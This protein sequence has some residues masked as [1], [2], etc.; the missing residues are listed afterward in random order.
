MIQRYIPVL[1]NQIFV[2]SIYDLPEPAVGGF[3][4]LEDNTFYEFAP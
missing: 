2:N 3:I 1:K 4:T